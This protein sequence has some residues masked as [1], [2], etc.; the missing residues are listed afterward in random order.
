MTEKNPLRRRHAWEPF[1]AYSKH[2]VMAVK[3]LA[4]GNATEGQQKRALSL[5]IEGIAGSY[6]PSYWPGS[7]TDT[8][9]AEGRRF[10]GL[11]LVKFVNM[12]GHLVDA[13]EK[14]KDV[15]RKR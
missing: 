12:S 11:Q 7:P 4:A 3:A 10:V 13:I 6:E 5:I 15:G 14:V 1:A 9:F 8:A 2:D